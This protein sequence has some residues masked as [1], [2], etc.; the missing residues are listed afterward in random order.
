MLEVV[1]WGS[2]NFYKLGTPRTRSLWGAAEGETTGGI[3]VALNTKV[4]TANVTCLQVRQI[5][6][7]DS[8]LLFHPPYPDTCPKCSLSTNWGMADM[9]SSKTLRWHGEISM[10]PR[11]RSQ[12]VRGKIFLPHFKG[13]CTKQ[14]PKPSNFDLVPL[15][16]TRWQYW[17]PNSGFSGLIWFGIRWTAEGSFSQ[18]WYWEAG[19]GNRARMGDVESDYWEDG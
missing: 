11:D 2:R 16:T 5:T 17:G 9:L 4:K 8:I 15:L 1:L 12:E 18:P 13:L 6:P 19:R 14:V 3:H 7:V 10:Y